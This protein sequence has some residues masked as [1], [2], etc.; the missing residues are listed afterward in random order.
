[1]IYPVIVITHAAFD[2]DRRLALRDLIS[3]LR[4]EAPDIDYLVQHDFDR[5]GSLWCWREGMR[6]ALELEEVTHVI[7]LP[8]DAVVCQDFGRIIRACIE[9]RP[10]DVFDCWVNHPLLRSHEV[11]SCWYSASDGGYTGMGG[12][13]PRDLLLE[14]L[15]WRDARPELGKYPNDAG[16]NM[17]AIDTGRRIYHTAWSL[18]RHRTDVA[19]LDGHDGQEAHGIERTGARWVDDE[20]QGARMDVM[21]FLGRTFM[22]PEEHMPGH[23]TS[24][25]M[26]GPTYA[27]NHFDMVRLLPPERWNL[28]GV[29]KAAHEPVATEQ[30]VVI[31]VP[32]YQEQADVLRKT[33]PSR[34]AAAADLEAHGI[35][36]SIVTPPSESHVDRMRQRATH[37]ALK[38][39]ATHILWW[40]ADIE[41][42]NP[43]AVR[44][45]L[46]TGHDVVAGACPYRAPGGKVVCNL[47]DETAEALAAGRGLTLER[48]CV[49]VLHAGTG[50]MLISRKALL[51]LM[52]AHPELCY[53]SRGAGDKGEPLWALWDASVVG[54]QGGSWAEEFATR[55][56]ETEDWFFCRQWQDH[57]GKVYVFVPAT[58]RHWGL[59]GYEASFES[60]WG[61][62]RAG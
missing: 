36:C 54:W 57:G 17:W 55:S 59:H 7:W 3:Q 42:L 29:Y 2:E 22:A 47:H 16:V 12:V 51:S 8:D 32:Q 28:D 60:Q 24:C 58:F 11:T 9:A 35:T 41:C 27:S 26:L 10:G 46:Q 33:N 48:G 45:M 61:L 21:N 14:H 52:Q 34:E 6:E 38:M 40:D 5:R 53:P 20:R 56:F 62:Q 44:A 31:L 18:V 1:M 39:G 43:T 49:E 19:S 13:M 37:L 50:F 23:R 4:L 25:A 30:H 15:A